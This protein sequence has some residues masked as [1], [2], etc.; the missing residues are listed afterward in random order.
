[1]KTLA[2]KILHIAEFLLLTLLFTLEIGVSAFVTRIV[3]DY[4]K[5]LLDYPS[6]PMFLQFLAVLFIASII[7]VF[8]FLTIIIILMVTGQV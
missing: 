7:G 8:M 2:N 4:A 6:I 5:C 1:M 3:I